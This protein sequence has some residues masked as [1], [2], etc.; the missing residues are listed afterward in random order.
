MILR[1][2]T[3]KNVTVLSRLFKIYVRPMLEYNSY[4]WS[5]HTASSVNFIENVQRRFTKRIFLRNHLYDSY[6]IRLRH[7]QLETLES[8]RL[9]S[10]LIMTYKIIHSLVDLNFHQY[11]SWAPLLNTTRSNHNYKLF[12]PQRKSNFFNKRIVK[13]WNSLPRSVA[14]SANLNI[15][16]Q[17]LKKVRTD[18]LGFTSLISQ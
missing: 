9:Q 5:P 4:V 7:L 18:C 14:E 3:T 11:F 13:Y 8:R 1:A 10:D 2:F 6:E 17:R 15:F 12:L 16:T